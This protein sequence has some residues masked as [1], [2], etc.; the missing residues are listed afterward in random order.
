M[1]R[2]IISITSNTSASST[3]YNIDSPDCR[4]EDIPATQS[5]A[6]LIQVQA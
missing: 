3:V 1:S 2:S 5:D 6:G 4:F